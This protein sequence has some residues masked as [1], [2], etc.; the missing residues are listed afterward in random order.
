MNQTIFQSVYD[1]LVQRDTMYDGIYY[2][3]IK[4]TGIVCRPSCKSRIPKKENVL[5]FQSVEDAIKAGFRPC[6]RCRPEQIG[7]WSPDARIAFDVKQIIKKSYSTS[8]TL[9]YLSDKMAISPYHLHR[10]FKRVTGMTP[11]MFLHKTRVSQAK[12]ILQE[13]DLTMIKVA[14]LVGFQSSSHFSMV[15]NRYTDMSPKQYRE[16]VKKEG[17]IIGF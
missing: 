2:T 3:A 10:V 5:L 1:S 12:Q 7:K 9:N 13:S 17:K 11:T 6:K 8:I 16:N 14:R 4:T 15:F